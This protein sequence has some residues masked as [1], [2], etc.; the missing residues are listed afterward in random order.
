M[1][2]IGF[3]VHG[4]KFG[5]GDGFLKEIKIRNMLSFRREVANI[6]PML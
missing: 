6:G 1:L 4:F 5:Q 3:K 2:A